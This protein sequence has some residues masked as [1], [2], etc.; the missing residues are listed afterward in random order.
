VI[1]CAKIVVR[2]L[3]EAGE[4]DPRRSSAIRDR[5]TLEELVDLGIRACHPT[6]PSDSATL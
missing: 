6:A 2:R 3:V 1:A 5:E 4:R